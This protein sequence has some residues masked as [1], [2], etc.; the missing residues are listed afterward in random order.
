MLNHRSIDKIL[1]LI[2]SRNKSEK[3]VA[4]K[5]SMSIMPSLADIL[6]A[7][8]KVWISGLLN[9]RLKVY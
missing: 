4:K 5:V 9:D 3:G 7:I 1:E 8:Y 2:S 6:I